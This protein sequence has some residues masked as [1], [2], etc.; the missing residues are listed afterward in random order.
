MSKRT[1]QALVIGGIAAVMAVSAGVAVAGG[2]LGSDTDRQAFLNDV[3]KRLD[4]TPAELKAAVRAS[5]ARPS[6]A[7]G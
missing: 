6:L 7:M 3:A 1:I 2:G 4:V 5:A